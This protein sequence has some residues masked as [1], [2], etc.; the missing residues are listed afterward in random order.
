MKKKTTK[1]TNPLRESLPEEKS[2]INSLSFAK[3]S[4]W[5]KF[6][7]PLINGED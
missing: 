6:E 2:V 1:T 5:W 7:H 3:L 4:S